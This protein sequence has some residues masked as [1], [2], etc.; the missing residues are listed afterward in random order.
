MGHI[1]SETRGRRISSIA[2]T[3]KHR[4]VVNTHF[5]LQIESSALL[6]DWAQ[7]VLKSIGADDLE[8]QGQAELA[9]LSSDSDIYYQICNGVK[10]KQQ[11]SMGEFQHC[12]NEVS[13]LGKRQTKST[14]SMRVCR[15]MRR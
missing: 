14:R 3:A 4:T 9:A 13:C 15:R 8:K 11:N 6:G 7:Q 10:T 1:S 5:S 12:S 2:A